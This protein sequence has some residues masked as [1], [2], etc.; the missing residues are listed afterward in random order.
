MATMKPPTGLI[1]MQRKLHS[2]PIQMHVLFVWVLSWTVTDRS[3]KLN[4]VTSSVR[5][6]SQTHSCYY[7]SADNTCRYNCRVSAQCTP[8]SW[9]SIIIVWK[10]NIIYLFAYCPASALQAKGAMLCY[11][12]RHFENGY[13]ANLYANSSGRVGTSIEGAGY[14]ILKTVPGLTRTEQCKR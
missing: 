12:W 3:Q 5:V 14:L 1:G 8:S 4:V 7:A 2:K 13:T 6:C 9:M 10:V 11:N